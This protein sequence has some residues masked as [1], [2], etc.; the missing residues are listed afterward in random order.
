MSL[1]NTRTDLLNLIEDPER[2]FALAGEVLDAERIAAADEL[3][4]RQRHRI[5]L[6]DRRATDAGVDA[7]RSYADIVPLLFSHTAYKS[8]PQSFYD[9]GRWDKMLQWL[10]TLSADDFSAVD[11]EGVSDVDDWLERLWAAGHAVIATSGTSGKVSF[12]NHTMADRARKTRHF[13]YTH[14]W[15]RVR[16]DNDHVLFWMG[17]SFGRTSAV[18][19][20]HTSVENW[21]RPGAVH[22]L[23]DE[24]LLI[25]EVSKAAAFRT[26][27]AAG[28]AT[29]DE[30]AAMASADAAK[31]ARV[32]EDL[33]KFIDTLL[34]HRD[35]PICVSGL[36]AQHMAILERARELGIGDGEFHPESIVSAGGGVKG[37]ALP[38]DY[39]DQVAR[40]WG[41]VVRTGTYGMTELSQAL[42]RCDGGRYHV[43][44]G[45]IVLPLDENGER[46][47]GKD[48]AVDGL[49]EAR[50]AFLD[51][52]VEGRWGGIITGDKVTIDLS[53]RCSCGRPGKTLLDN[54]TRFA[55]PGQ[56]DH[57]GC[58]GTIDAYIRGVV[59]S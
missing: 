30:I 49:L 13:K 15:P 14:G 33:D 8:Y 53:D 35:Q 11:I 36:W 27:M 9:K 22:A 42:P 50:F 21:A 3:F 37:V 39:Q 16:S 29:P 56:D 28:T 32:R 23:S 44:P 26:K 12:L 41:D 5:S 10:S 46:L 55:R 34:A 58:A 48:D 19:A 25:S 51:L 38:G 20:F 24:P 4:Q 31:S 1:P 40:F 45:L 43:A 7:I 54:I 17:P 18:E 57:I 2:A 52:G 6:L 59:G 47:L